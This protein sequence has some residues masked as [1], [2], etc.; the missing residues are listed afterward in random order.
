MI[1]FLK[2]LFAYDKEKEIARLKEQIVA[3][4]V[5]VHIFEQ[6]KIER[7]S[8]LQEVISAAKKLAVLE[9]KLKL[10]EDQNDTKPMDN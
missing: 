8:L 2:G 4:K 3:A 6:V 10:L 5:E 1:E 7:Y 9:H